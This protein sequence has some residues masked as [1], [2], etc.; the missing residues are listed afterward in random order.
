MLQR[1]DFVYLLQPVSRM[2]EKDIA[3]ASN[4]SDLSDLKPVAYL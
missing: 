1:K 3:Y 2:D 4:M